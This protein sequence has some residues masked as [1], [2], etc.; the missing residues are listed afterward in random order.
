MKANAN[1]TL[2]GGTVLNDKW[3]ILEFIG[4]GRMGEIYR[5]HQLN[6]KRDVAIWELLAPRRTL[7]ISKISRWI[8]NLGITFLNPLDISNGYL[9]SI[10]NDFLRT[11]LTVNNRKS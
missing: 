9:V 11:E 7:T 4:K 10:S 5:G 3:S 2:R 1:N 8:S 6:L